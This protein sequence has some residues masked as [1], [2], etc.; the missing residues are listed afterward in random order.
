MTAPSPQAPREDLFDQLAYLSGHFDT[1]SSQDQRAV[2][3][4]QQQLVRVLGHDDLSAVRHQFLSI[5]GSD[6]FSSDAIPSPQRAR[7]SQLVESVE[8]IGDH[9]PEL[10]VFVRNVPVRST[11]IP[12]S[13][14]AWA[15]GAS[16]AQTLGPFTGVDG[17]PYWFDFFRITRLVALYVQGSSEPVLLFNAKVTSSL[18]ANARTA[19]ELVPDSIWINAKLLASNAPAGL[20]A[21]LMIRRGTLTL[22]APPTVIGS[23]WTLAATTRASVAL[24]L[25]STAS[26][27]TDDQ[28]PY[29][30][31]ARRANVQLP[32]RFAFHFTGNVGAIDEIGEDIS[33]RVYGQTMSFQWSSRR[34][35]EYDPT[36]KHLLIP[37]DCSERRIEITECQSPINTLA[38]AADIERSAWALPVAELDITRP[39]AAEGLGGLAT[40]CGQG[41]TTQW[42]GL[43]GGAVRLSNPWLLCDPGRINVSELLAGSEFCAQDYALWTDDANPHG[44][45]IK[46][47]Y[48]AS[49][50]FIYNSFAN[51]NEVYLAFADARS[52]LDR[53]VGVDGKPQ[54]IH[55][56]NTAVLVAAS[57]VQRLLYLYDDNIL[58]DNLDPNRPRAAPP[59]PIAIALRNALFKVTPINGCMLFGTM[60]EDLRR[61][62]RGVVFLTFGV[63]AYV[64]TLPDPYA[65][66]LGELRAQFERISRLSNFSNAAQGVWMWLVA[67]ISWQPLTQDRDKVEVSFHFAPLQNQF[68]IAKPLDEAAASRVAPAAV[69]TDRYDGQWGE[70][71]GSLLEDDFALLDVSSNANQLGVSFAFGGG[72]M[73]FVRT[74]EAGVSNAEGTTSVFPVQLRGLDVM[75]RARDVRA[76]LPPVVSWEPVVNLT[77]PEKPKNDPPQPFNYYP[78]DG[79]PARIFN[80]SSRLVALAPTP[81]YDMLTDAYANE[82]DTVTVASFTLPFGIRAIASLSKNDDSQRKKP[83]IA[84]NR[85][86]FDTLEGGLQFK[87]VAGSEKSKMQD[88][89]FDGYTLQTAN[90]LDWLGNATGT[91]TLG[92]DV[93]GIFNREFFNAAPGV[94][95]SRIDIS[96]YGASTFTDWHNR[97][98]QFG[99]TS[100]VR[101]D[102]VTGRTAHEVIQVKSILYPWGIH[103][104][105]TITLYRAGSGYVYRVDSGWK[106]ESDGRFDFSFNYADKPHVDNDH[107]APEYPYIVHPGVVKGLFNV[108]NIRTAGKEVLP[109]KEPMD[110][111]NFYV[112]DEGI[113]RTVKAGPGKHLVGVDLQPVHFDADVE[114]ENVIQGAVQGRVPGKK[115]LGFVQIAPIGIPLTPEKF[116]ELLDRQLGS[117][118]G[119]FACTMDIGNSG[120]KL[121]VTAIDVNASVD[122]DGVSP[123]FVAASRGHVVL[124]KEGSWSMV[125]HARGTGDVTPLPEH[126]SVPLVRAGK[127]NK[128]LSVPDGE[129]LRIANPRDLLRAPNDDTV[130]F[131]FLQSTNTQK[132]LFLTP[133]FARQATNTVPGKLLSK[134]PP[135]FVDA[136]RLVGSKAIFPNIGDAET[137]FGSAITLAENFA[138]NALQ[139]GGKKVFELM[140][141]SSADGVARLQ[142]DGYRLANAVRN[143]KLPDDPWHLIDESYLKIYVEYKATTKNGDLK[144]TQNRTGSLDFDVDSFSSSVADRW[145]SRLNNMAMVV[146]LGPFERLVSIKGNFDARKGSEASYVGDPADPTNFA[147]PQMELSPALEK[148]KDILRILESLQGGDYAD[149]AKRGL[150]IAMSNDADSWEYKF[151]ASQEIPLLKFP[152]GFLAND[153][154]AALKLQASLKFGIYFNAALKTESLDDPKKLLPSAGAFLEFDGRLSVMCVSISIAT[155]YAVGQ[156]TLRISGDT[157]NGPMVDMK[158]GFGAQVVVGLPVVGNV[159]VMYVVGVA[160]HLEA[161]E[162]AVSAFLMYEG[163]AE[164][165]AGLISI[166]IMIEAKGTVKRIADADAKDDKTWLA[167][168]VTF[169]LDISLF[170][171]IDIEFSKSWEEQRQLAGPTL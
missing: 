31:D 42:P 71:F 106:A 90:V 81:V 3:Q 77:A 99:T 29:G 138:Q 119:P 15:A 126:V 59:V 18:F 55:S 155:V 151:E 8:S 16:V 136:Y 118:G 17:R 23:K 121:R 2:E 145:K 131:G 144:A 47:S 109:F 92:Q 164:L 35:P 74:H 143:F 120:Q 171:V 124:P 76:F 114:L 159:S 134:T 75:A 34:A 50:P 20:L 4:L 79:D 122:A 27:A 49:R 152:P 148:A 68:A 38:G 147:A 57:K 156:C 112:Y 101:F 85:P 12:G 123:I 130:N 64:P 140:H 72:Q 7:L 89:L 84:S 19:H 24:E 56:Q 111:A 30:I 67:E 26:P 87:L 69:R 137:G 132:V 139:D 158:F 39:S 36:L 146:D 108:Q 46:L 13:T 115:I 11:L 9:A 96:G 107:S 93:A 163:H 127:M 70:R 32:K 88:N 102:I 80:N 65:A 82:K 167:A 91:S 95:I 161:K 129:L 97:D 21:G 117:I 94:P 44:A 33:R 128:D 162:L 73:D 37:L 105:R 165:L 45:T 53:P 169:A 40:R 104:V 66:N 54:N 133:A 6:L 150:R 86:V 142:E 98:A 61:V 110:V 154:N 41:L 116:Q 100:Q 63:F 58:F 28:S 157:R 14:P 166:T 135:L 125:S 52:H 43:R 168:Q 78:D 141:I 149:V 160:I 170:L 1:A 22:S 103:V 48:T 51:G 113:G 5:D 153:P 10:R 62:E 83:S 25:D 60:A